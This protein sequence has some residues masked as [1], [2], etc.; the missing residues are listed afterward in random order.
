MKR[1]RTLT[2][3]MTLDQ[4][5]SIR[6]CLKNDIVVNQ[7]LLDDQ[8][9]NSDLWERAKNNVTAF[10]SLQKVLLGKIDKLRNND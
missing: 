9:G 10:Q 2:L 7:H 6:E 8:N 5:I 4:A 1:N 3:R